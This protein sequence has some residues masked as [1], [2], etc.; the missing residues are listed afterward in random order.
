MW[1]RGPVSHRTSIRELS[2]C[3][4]ETWACQLGIGSY[5]IWSK[6]HHFSEIPFPHLEEEEEGEEG[7][8]GGGGEGREGGGGGGRGGGKS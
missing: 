7:G 8:G 5:L 1:L 4:K 6:K 3:R 2:A